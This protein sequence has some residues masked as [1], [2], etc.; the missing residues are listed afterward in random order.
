MRAAV[1]TAI[2]LL[3]LGLAGLVGYILARRT[4]TGLW[5]RL[6]RARLA[7]LD[8]AA[9]AWLQSEPESLPRELQSLLP[10]PDRGLFVGICQ[11][12]LVN[13]DSRTRARLVNWLESNGQIERWLRQLRRRS[14]WRRAHAAELLGIARVERSTEQLVAA[15]QDPVFDVRMRAANA[16]GALGG[17]AARA[18]LVGALANENRWSVI[19]ISDLLAEM[20]PDVA[21]EL[22]AAYPDMSRSAR[23]ATLDV[24]A[25]V[26]DAS[27]TPFL[28]SLLNDLDR[29]VR[30]RS[31]AALGRI[32]DSRANAAL[33]AGL[34]DSEWPVRA[35]CAKALAELGTEAAIPALR[36][37]L[38]DREWWVR[39]NAAEALG[40][41]GAPGADEL[42]QALDDQDEFARDQALA[43]LEA[44]GELYRRLA[45]LASQTPGDALVAR[46]LLDCLLSRQPRDRVKAIGARHPDA[47]VRTA[48]AQVLPPA[49]AGHGETT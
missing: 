6:E 45:G 35:M 7:R 42:V 11:V 2:L 3:V 14:V 33:Q 27:A 22:V 48:I 1:A 44:S 31:A 40:R 26:G 29:D 49:P 19:R 24:I 17:K 13:A 25:K 34:Q 4:V 15:L 18:A 38:R 5:S 46:L 10:F 30:A 43:T 20:G 41:L 12:R 39:A 47:A 16:L 28:K 9:D 21:G 36:A 8:A 37:S 23:V 32:G